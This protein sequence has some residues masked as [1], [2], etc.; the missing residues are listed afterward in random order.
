MT[1]AVAARAQQQGCPSYLEQLATAAALEL[2]AGKAGLAAALEEEGVK[3]RE[4]LGR[5]GEGVANGTTLNH[6]LSRWEVVSG[7]LAVF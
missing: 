4:P 2:F 3:T 1:D 6:D 5:T 7:I